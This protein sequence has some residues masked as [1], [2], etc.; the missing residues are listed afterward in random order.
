MQM[1]P[2][3]IEFPIR[4]IE[5]NLAFGQDGSVWAYYEI[6]PYDYSYRSDNEKKRMLA[7]FQAMYSY[8][9]E[10]HH[11]IQVPSYTDVKSHNERLKRYATNF[12]DEAT[13]YLERATQVINQKVNSPTDV[14]AFVG[15]RLRKVNRRQIKDRMRR[16]WKHKL[17]DF[18]RYLYTT[19]GIEPGDILEE[20]LFEYQE[21]EEALYQ[22]LRGLMIINKLTA[23]DFQ[24]YIRQHVFQGIG[25]PPVRNDWQP[26]VGQV[27]VKGRKVIKPGP[28]ILT[29][30]NGEF[31]IDSFNIRVR[32][33]DEKEGRVKDGYMAFLFATDFPEDPEFPG[34]AEWAYLAN[35]FDFPVSVSARVEVMSNQDALE[36]LNKRKIRIQNQV[37]ETRTEGQQTDAYLEST[38]HMTVEKEQ[39]VREGGYP[40]LKMTAVFGLSAEDEKTLNERINKVISKYRQYGIELQLSPGDQFV[41]FSDF[42]PAGKRY[43]KF[44]THIIE[45]S[46]IAGAMMGAT[47]NLGDNRGFMFGYT[48]PRS[49]SRLKLS[50][51]VF[52]HPAL[53][54]QGVGKSNSLSM[55]IFGQT[56][57]GKSLAKGLIMYLTTLLFDAK[58]LKIDP[59]GECGEWPK[60]MPFIG[61]HINVITLGANPEDK[62]KLDPYTMFENP[63]EAALYAKDMLMQLAS[64]KVTDPWA[65]VIHQAVQEVRKELDPAKRSLTEV[66]RLIKKEDQML[67]NILESYQDYAFSQLLFGDGKTKGGLQLDAPM[68]ILQVQGLKLPDHRTDQKDYRD[69]ERLSQALMLSISGFVRQFMEQDRSVLKQIGWD[70]AWTAM[71]SDLSKGI[72]DSVI[73]EGRQKNTGIILATQNPTDIDDSLMDNIGIKLVFKLEELRQVERALEILKL[74]KT[75]GNIEAIQNLSHGECFFRDIFGRVGRMY[76]DPLFQE[77][78]TALDTKPPEKTNDGE[79]V[80]VIS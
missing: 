46:L 19:A 47:Q 2:V 71:K 57:W 10:E 49:V 25:Q 45:P 55:A 52:L 38:Y 65:N 42:L 12:K 44:F 7:R 67:F 63:R 62:G 9:S 69:I 58:T 11:F 59:K 8:I 51:P 32:Q 74:E 1:K 14:R 15:F 17:Q 50:K 31:D 80:E 26:N 79:K 24:W 76:V 61:E 56:G 75:Q 43:A 20:E 77:V 60:T 73:R 41:G 18:T 27:D 68:N 21:Q 37:N 64:V 35:A 13:M 3:Q 48:G 28:S 66:L 70:E 34:K 39:D 16:Q 36:Q 40:L 30:A 23:Q 72:I 33:F 53:A 6:E 29:L 5:G 54:A 4:H 22:E 78:M